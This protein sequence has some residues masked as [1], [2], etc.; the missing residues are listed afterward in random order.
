LSLKPG[1]FF[2]SVVDFFG[3]LVPGALLALL[4]LAPAQRY[5]FNGEVLPHVDGEPATTGLFLV[6]A[7]VCGQATEAVGSFLLD[8]VTDHT[9]RASKAKSSQALIERVRELRKQII[10][11]AGI[12]QSDFR[13]AR[14]WVR[15]TSPEGFA[16]IERLGANAKFFRGLAVVFAIGALLFLYE[17]HIG[18]AIA[19]ALLFLLWL[20]RDAVQRWQRDKAAFEYVIVEAAAR[21]LKDHERSGDAASRAKPDPSP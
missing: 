1:D 2:V 8:W 6:M 12:V 16:A 4:I 17:G 14:L 3:I 20:Y 19:A 18:L 7:Y 21:Q 9:Y 11:D 10:G 5:L 15:T 13:W